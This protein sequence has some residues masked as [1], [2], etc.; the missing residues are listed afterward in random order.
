[1]AVVCSCERGQCLIAAVFAHPLPHPGP[2]AVQ[3]TNAHPSYDKMFPPCPAADTL[4]G[5]LPDPPGK[6]CHHLKDGVF[7][8]SG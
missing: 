4:G 6:V 7:H 3:I 1:M 8:S 2:S 5:V